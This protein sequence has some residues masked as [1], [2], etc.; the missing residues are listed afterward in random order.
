MVKRI[1]LIKGKVKGEERVSRYVN[2][3]KISPKI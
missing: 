1:S 3:L 2:F